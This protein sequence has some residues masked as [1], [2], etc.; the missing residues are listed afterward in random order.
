MREFL[1]VCPVS[2]A[3]SLSGSL[4]CRIGGGR[5]GVAWSGESGRVG[6]GG[7]SLSSSDYSSRFLLVVGWD[8]PEG[9]TS[10]SGGLWSEGRSGGIQGR[11]VEG[12]DCGD[13]RGDGGLALSLNDTGEERRLFPAEGR[14]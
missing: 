10:T 11:G 8:C 12:G 4:G 2:S 1:K 5:G 6:S 14:S 13:G 7:V 9:S 3:S